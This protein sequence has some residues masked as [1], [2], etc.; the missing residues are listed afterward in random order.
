M[1]VTV[2][3]VFRL[4]QTL[5]TVTV[6]LD[7]YFSELALWTFTGNEPLA[8]APVVAGNYLYVASATTTYVVNRTTHQLVWQSAQGG[9][10]AVANGFLYVATPDT[11]LHAFRAQE[12]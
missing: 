1:T 11:R 12:P 6:T 4:P 5:R 10:L 7:S 9:T 8:Y 3:K 2:Q